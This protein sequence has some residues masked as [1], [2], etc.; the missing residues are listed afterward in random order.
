MNCIVR[1][2]KH[3][4]K[5]THRVGWSLLVLETTPLHGNMDG[6][7]AFLLVSY[8]S[9]SDKHVSGNRCIKVTTGFVQVPD[10]ALALIVGSTCLHSYVTCLYTLNGAEYSGCI[11][12]LLTLPIVCQEW[13]SLFAHTSPMWL[14]FG[15][16]LRLINI[17]ERAP[18]RHTCTRLSTSFKRRFISSAQKKIRHLSDLH[19]RLLIAVK[20][21]FDSRKRDYARILEKMID[22]HFPDRRDLNINSRSSLMEGF[23]LLNMC[24]R[25]G[26]YKCIKLLLHTYGADPNIPDIGGFTPLL[27]AA[28]RGD[29]LIVQLLLKSGAD[30]E[31]VGCLR[32]GTPQV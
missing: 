31:A 5:R 14:I 27:H 15:K 25:N 12:S 18:Q 16:V 11:R 2:S 20:Q 1:D 30:L 17:T 10:L 13:N 19:Q 24:A 26:R 32:G 29:M 21:L 7:L 22:S 8:I 6:L 28:Y 9:C 23:T 3:N 4:T